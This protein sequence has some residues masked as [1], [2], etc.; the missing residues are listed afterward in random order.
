MR[1][2][3]LTKRHEKTFRH[4]IMLLDSYRNSFHV[5][6][7]N[8]ELKMP[9]YLKHGIKENNSEEIAVELMKENFEIYI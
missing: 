4:A 5:K 6:Y 7:I 8:N 1:N 9:I 3:I 2:G